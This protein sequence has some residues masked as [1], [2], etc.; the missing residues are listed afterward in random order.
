MKKT[1]YLI[2]A[3][4]ISIVS[5]LSSCT[6]DEN[7]IYGEITYKDVD[8]GEEYYLDK[9]TKVY[10]MEEGEV[11]ITKAY[12]VV[13]ILDDKGYYKFDLVDDGKYYVY[14]EIT[15]VLQLHTYKGKSETIDVKGKD[16]KEV[17]VVLK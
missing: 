1:I 16:V 4:T 11:D 15:D 17:N 8:D 9:G 14:S 2:F 3:F 5:I 10:L 13:E 12:N 7:M 6:S